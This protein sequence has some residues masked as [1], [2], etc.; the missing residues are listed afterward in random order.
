MAKGVKGSSPKIEDKPVRTSFIIDPAINK[1]LNYISLM[2]DKE[3]TEVV[4]SAFTDLISKWEKKNG[5]IPV[6]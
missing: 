5:K 1:K 2:D 3:K 6:K 4:N